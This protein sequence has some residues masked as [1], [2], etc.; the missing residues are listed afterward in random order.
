MNRPA[1]DSGD[2][3]ISPGEGRYLCGLLYL[4]LSQGH[5]V[6]T[7]ELAGH[8]GVSDATVTEM[9][10]SFGDRGL[11]TYEPYRGSEL[12]DRGE[13]IARELLWRRCVVQDFFD[14]TAGISLD[15]ERAFQIGLQLTGA[16]ADRLSEQI[17]QPCH[18]HC[19]A[20]DAEDCSVLAT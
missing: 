15:E 16:E 6:S 12:T 1:A 5:H 18:G 4:T 20:V 7:G 11:V 8:L 14:Q 17:S 9:I 10:K 19:E 3:P 13:Q 2:Q